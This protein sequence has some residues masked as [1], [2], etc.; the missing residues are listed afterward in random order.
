MWSVIHVVCYICG[1]LHMLCEVW[2]VRCVYSYL[3]FSIFFKSLFLSPSAPW[4]ET[5]PF[6][7]CGSEVPSGSEPCC[8]ASIKILSGS[9]RLFGDDAFDTEFS[10]DNVP[11]TLVGDFDFFGDR[12]DRGDLGDR[13]DRGDSTFP[14]ELMLITWRLFEIQSH[15]KSI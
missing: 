4:P 12:G 1:L 14:S 3:T 15:L 13:G 8:S 10:S 11:L 5:G 6:V 9:R 2:G 7:A